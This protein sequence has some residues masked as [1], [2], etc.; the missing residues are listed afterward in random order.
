MKLRLIFLFSLIVL[1][2]ACDG[3]GGGND[4]GSG[5]VIT[6]ERDVSGFDKVQLTGSGIAEIIQGDS[7]SLI[8]EAE[9]NVM[10]FVETE[11][12]D[13]VLV[14]SQKP[15]FNINLTKPIRYTITMINVTGLEVTGS[16]AINSNQI[17]TSV[18]SLGITG[19]GDIN[20]DAL[21]GD[22]VDAMISGSGNMTMIGSVADQVVEISGSGEYRAG[23][24]RSATAVV[25]VGGSGD[26]TVWVDTTLDITIG[27]SG[28]V[29]YFGDPIL[30]QSVTGSGAV[31]SLGTK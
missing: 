21:D 15:N 17:D 8:V 5:N 20:I 14:L 13:G 9:D 12:K 6:Q 2:A 19:S 26:A 29:G 25:T 16:G 30:T 28:E 18:I 10:P 4:G 7:V 23:D 3:I 27:G 11:V 24:L 1:L 22:S 31:R